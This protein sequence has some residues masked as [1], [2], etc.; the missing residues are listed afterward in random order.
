MIRESNLQVQ[1][2][3]TDTYLEKPAPFSL[4]FLKAY[5]ASLA[6][7]IRLPLKVD[8]LTVR[9]KLKSLK[10][11][12]L[13][14]ARVFRLEDLRLDYRILI[15]GLLLC[16]GA[17]GY[18]VYQM[19][20]LRRELVD[21]M[22]QRKAVASIHAGA[23]QVELTKIAVSNKAKLESLESLINGQVYLT[24][25]FNAIS[26]DL[27]EGVWFIGLSLVKKEGG[28]VEFVLEGRV[29]LGDGD[30]EFEAVNNLLSNLQNSPDFAKYF[31]QITISSLNRQTSGELLFPY[32]LFSI[33]CRS[34]VSE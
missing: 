33:S 12:A 28:R 1:S 22:A 21:V 32:T 20:P 18:G 9:E 26:R 13:P 27:P 25:I 3:N 24:E 15:L 17:Y 31:M 10:E 30:Q 8:L 19:K 7:T 4:S 23:G 16:A 11:R 5:S 14:R 34:Y 6:K 29:N 2:L